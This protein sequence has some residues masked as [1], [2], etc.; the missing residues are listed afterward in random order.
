MF[1]LYW[2]HTTIIQELYQSI[3]NM[4]NVVFALK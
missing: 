2:D 1:L 3:I 4:V